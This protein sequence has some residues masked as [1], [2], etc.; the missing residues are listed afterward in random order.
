MFVADIKEVFFK[1][2]KKVERNFPLFS[3][4]VSKAV[5]LVEKRLVCILSVPAA[6]YIACENSRFFSLLGCFR[7]LLSKPIFRLLSCATV[8]DITTWR[9]V[10]KESRVSNSGD[11]DS[12]FMLTYFSQ[13]PPFVIRSMTI[14]FNLRIWGFDGQ[15]WVLI[16]KCQRKFDRLI[17]EMI[18]I[19]EISIVTIFAATLLLKTG[20]SGMSGKLSS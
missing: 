11:K 7:R 2:K 19:K 16:K 10:S 9:N 8:G 5:V 13:R 18:F 12:Y 20:M 4:M 1:K 3:K 15:C 14:L 6:K 17:Y